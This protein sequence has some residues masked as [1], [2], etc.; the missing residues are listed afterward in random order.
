VRG[1][2]NPQAQG[3]SD[4][5]DSEGGPKILAPELKIEHMR[6]NLSQAP[7]LFKKRD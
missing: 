2:S 3:K 5:E 7:G 1:Q 6:P 4:K